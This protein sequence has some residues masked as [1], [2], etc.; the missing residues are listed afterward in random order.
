MFKLVSLLRTFHIQPRADTISK[1]SHIVKCWMFE[2][3]RNIIQHITEPSL[4]QIHLS[5]RRHLL[6]VQAA[7]FTVHSFLHF[8]WSS[9]LVDEKSL[10]WT[11]KQGRKGHVTIVSN[12]SCLAWKAQVCPDTASLISCQIEGRDRSGAQG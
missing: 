3:C 12:K 2:C 4:R 11:W 7:N 10:A 8:L 5:G 6:L 1:Y 9:S